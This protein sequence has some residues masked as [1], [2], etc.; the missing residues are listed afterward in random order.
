M[1]KES[2]FNQ[3]LSTNFSKKTTVED[4]LGVKVSDDLTIQELY[5]LLIEVDD[6]F[7]S[8]FGILSLKTLLFTKPNNLSRLIHVIKARMS[9]LK[10]EDQ[11]E[12]EEK[13]KILFD[14][15]GKFQGNYITPFFKEN[16]SFRTCHYCNRAYTTDITVKKKNSKIET[17]VTYQLDHFYEK[18]HYPYLAL[19]FYNFIPCCS[20]CNTT[21]KNR[22]VN[23]KED[24]C[25]SKKCLAPNRE[26]FDF[27]IQV[28]FKTFVKNGIL[29]PKKIDDFNLQLIEKTYEK[30]TE[31]ISLF[32][33]NERYESHKDIVL[34]MIRKREKYPDSR[35]K[36]LSVLT[37]QSVEKVKQDLFG[38][39]IF[40]EDLLNRPLSKLTQDIARALDLI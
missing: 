39:E 14:Y 9:R 2:Y 31:Y 36:E 8:V 23:K 30:Y 15:S 28:T 37:K 18:S 29:K 26:D 10:L 17:I 12:V 27:N 16:F 3:L 38:S 33:L 22:A 40:D 25:Y 32:K 11:D 1:L 4:K 20:T 24:D 19:S 13:L 35:I 5:D 21:V 34:E 6:I 7:K